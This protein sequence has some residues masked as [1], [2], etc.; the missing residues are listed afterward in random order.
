MFNSLKLIGTTVPFDDNLLW[1]LVGGMQSHW[2]ELAFGRAAVT[3]SFLRE[4]DGGIGWFRSYVV[5]EDGDDVGRSL[6]IELE[7]ELALGMC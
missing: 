7:L 1:V 4:K 5:M 3:A 2:L 6:R